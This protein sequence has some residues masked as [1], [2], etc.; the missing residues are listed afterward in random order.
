MPLTSLSLDRPYLRTYLILKQHAN[1]TTT[2]VEVEDLSTNVSITS[3]EK[4]PD[5]N[6]SLG[7]TGDPTG[8]IDVSGSSVVE[9]YENQD[10][11]LTFRIEAYPPVRN[12]DWTTPTHING[13]NHTVYR[14]IY[15]DSDYRLA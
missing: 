11:T 1:A 15:T 10:V 4:E 3:V 14:E 12:Q 13:N 5:A 8:S 6:V 7:W 9:V 2:T